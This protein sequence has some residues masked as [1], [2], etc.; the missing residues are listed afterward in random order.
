MSKQITIRDVAKEAGVSYQTV[1]R[2]LNNKGEISETTKQHVLDVAQRMGYRPS[3]LARGLTTNRTYTIG[4]LVPDISI[5]FFSLMVKGAEAVSAAAGYS[6]Y[7]VNTLK[8][9]QLET[10]A[11]DTLWDRRVDG[12]VLYASLLSPEQL[13]MYIERFEHAVF[14]NCLNVPMIEGKSAAINVDDQEGARLAVS[15]FIE[16]GHSKI[17]FL[18]GPEIS[19]SGRR[20][21]DGFVQGFKDYDLVADHNL[22]YECVPYT[23]GGYDTTIQLLKD[24]P[25]VT[26]VLAYNDMTAVGAIRACQDM[27]RKI[28]DDIAI[29][30]FD[31]IPM[32]SVFR[33]TLTTVRIGKQDLGRLAMSTLIAM[34]EG[35]ANSVETKQVITPQL[36]VRDSTLKV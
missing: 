31:D 28:P 7:L 24:H 32:A 36:V 21:M 17:A 10:S 2:A 27:G 34:I 15:H 26:A 8:D 33:P 18:S 16:N 13:R 19:I 1:S 29:S 9:L 3:S 30:G 14:I 20:R 25:D 35:E 6:V 12:A 22:I 5:H 23:Q 11:L 4:L